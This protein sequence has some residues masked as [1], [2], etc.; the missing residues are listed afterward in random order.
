MQE[1]QKLYENFTGYDISPDMVRL[2]LVN[3]YLHGF[4]KPQIHEYDT[5]ASE[6]RWNEYADVILA[7]PPFM[8]PKGG[9]HAAQTVSRCSRT[10]VKCC[11]W[12]TWRSISRQT[13]APPS[14]CPRALSF[15]RQERTSNYAN[16]SSSTIILWAVVSLP[17]GVFNPYAGVKTSI[18]FLD[19]ILAKKTDQVLFVKVEN[20]GFDLGAQRRPIDRNDSA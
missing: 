12:I 2:S 5:L 13:D 20:D 17:A 15:N 1:K 16:I 18:L 19:K 14:L 6:E 4:V 10:A 9:I 3:L 8:S 11:S 7:N